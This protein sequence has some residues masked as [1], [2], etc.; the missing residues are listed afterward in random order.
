M[1]RGKPTSIVEQR[2]TLGTF[3]RQWIVEQENYL[4]SQVVQ[5]KLSIVAVPVATAVSAAVMGYAIYLAA[6]KLGEGLSGVEF[7][8]PNPLDIVKPIV[9]PVYDTVQVIN[10][11]TNSPSQTAQRAILISKFLAWAGVKPD[12]IPKE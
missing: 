2:I 8:I 6:G 4:K 5:A 11:M 7:S 3:E 10:P 1:P 9:K 12:E